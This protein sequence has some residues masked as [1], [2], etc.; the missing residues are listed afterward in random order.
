MQPWEA[1]RIRTT[2][3]QSSPLLLAYFKDFLRGRESLRS[4]GGG[5]EALRSFKLLFFFLIPNLL[6]LVNPNVITAITLQAV[7]LHSYL[8]QGV[9]FGPCFAGF[10][11]KV[12]SSVA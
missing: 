5:E 3:K 8:G 11:N 10:T 12:N 7:Q 9:N 6:S 2:F 4:G 1:Q